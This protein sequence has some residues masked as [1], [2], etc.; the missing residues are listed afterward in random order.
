MSTRTAPFASRHPFTMVVLA[1][2]GFLLVI[3]A[4]GFGVNALAV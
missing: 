4:L 3:A 2:V 1:T